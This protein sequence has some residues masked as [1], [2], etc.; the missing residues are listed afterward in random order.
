VLAWGLFLL[1]FFSTTTLGAVWSVATRTD[2]VTGLEL[3]LTP[4]TIQA[5]W[6]EPALLKLGLGVSLPLL[7]ILFCHEM[8]HY[9]ACRRY[10]L[11]TTLPYFLPAPIGLGT[12]GAFIR[13]RAPIA[14]KRQLFDVGAS[15]PFAGFAA[16]L[17]FLVYGLAHSR[18]AYL[19]VA[20]KA[21]ETLA[22]I[23]L[24]GQN[25]A[26]RLGSSFFHG[27]LP[28][29]YVLDLHPFALAAW[30]GLLATAINLI[31]LGQLDGGH[32]LYAVLGRAQRRL[33]IP[34]WIGL[35]IAALF[36]RGWLIWCVLVLIL[37]LRHPPLRD[38]SVPLDRE[39]LFLAL[40]AL[41]ILI[42]SF[43]PIPIDIIPVTG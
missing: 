42:L 9:L 16:L 35:G 19:P 8:G 31:P 12:F 2:V 17:P 23:F 7:L 33:A 3:L 22:V 32:I 4:T 34:L 6:T 18:P 1:A 15:G 39:R 43:I 26:M 28:H 37:G 10:G 40:I 24:P 13:I 5:V 27:P 41:G 11:P 38:E 30:F 20:E 21:E 14:N 29:G 36:Y 25:L